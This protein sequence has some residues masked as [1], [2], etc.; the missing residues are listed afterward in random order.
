MK[1]DFFL[2][3]IANTMANGLD[4]GGA[5]TSTLKPWYMG[6]VLWESSSL[7]SGKIITTATVDNLKSRDIYF[8]TAST[9][10]CQLELKIVIL[11]RTVK[12]ADGHTL[13]KKV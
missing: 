6:S 10:C 7:V 1:S 2:S 12:R 13:P 5:G 11:V 3:Y 9:I 8:S 4:T